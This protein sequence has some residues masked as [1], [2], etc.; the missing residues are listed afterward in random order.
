[1]GTETSHN[2]INLRDKF[3]RFAEHWAPKV[4]AE[5]NDYQIKVVKLTG[6]FV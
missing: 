1:M 3:N 5:L 2:P 6:E 4:V